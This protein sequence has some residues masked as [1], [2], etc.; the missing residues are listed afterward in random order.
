MPGCPT[1]TT[2]VD[3]Q[4]DNNV[5]HGIA[6][7]MSQGNTIIGNTALGNGGGTTTVYASDPPYTDGFDENVNPP[8]DANV[9]LHNVFGTVNQPCVRQHPGPFPTPTP[10]AAATPAP[11]A[12][13]HSPQPP[14]PAVGPP[15]N[16]RSPSGAEGARPQLRTIRLPSAVAIRLPTGPTIDL[17]SAR[18]VGPSSS[19]E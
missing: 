18:A 12:D 13:H 3:N 10:L 6:I 8:C 16:L 1:R 4:V 14:R 2:I 7:G 5:N 19:P 17:T 15:S 11:V 9:W